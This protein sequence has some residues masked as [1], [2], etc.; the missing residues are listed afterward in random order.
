MNCIFCNGITNASTI[1]HILPESLVSKKWAVL[2]PG[3]VCKSCNQYFGSK[4]ESLALASFPFLPFR[5]LLAIPAKHKKP[6]K[7]QTYLGT[8]KSNF[9]P[10]QIGIDPISPEVEETMGLTGIANVNR[11]ERKG[12]R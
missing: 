1:E 5:L 11:C 8:V 3:F 7:M 4:V 6:P 2:P 10:S 12:S 9:L